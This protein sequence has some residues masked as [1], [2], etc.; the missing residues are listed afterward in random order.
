MLGIGSAC[1][2]VRAGDDAGEGVP[3]G[4]LHLVF[5]AQ[6]RGIDEYELAELVFDRG[7]DS[8]TGSTGNIRDDTPVFAGNPVYS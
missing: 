6:T 2:R 5:P 8:V 1:H 4:I 7:I 3:D